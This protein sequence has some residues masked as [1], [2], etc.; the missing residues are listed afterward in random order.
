MEL[1][2]GM[3]NKDE[4]VVLQLFIN[5]RN[6]KILHISDEIS[7]KAIYYLEQFSLSHH[8]RMADAL[9]A[10]T[11]FMTKATLLTANTKHYRAIHEINTKSFRP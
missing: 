5:Q 10:A 7:Q 4:L 3:R 9:I 8:L 11:A 2:Q 6:I 1:V